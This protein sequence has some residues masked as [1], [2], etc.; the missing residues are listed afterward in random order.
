MT[1][2]AIEAYIDRHPD[3]FSPDERKI[4][5][6]FTDELV[7]TVRDIY[8]GTDVG[9]PKPPF[10]GD[11]TADYWG[12]VVTWLKRTVPACSGLSDQEIDLAITLAIGMDLDA[13]RAAGPRH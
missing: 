7:W 4:G 6:E 11:D 9:D 12:R 10:G 8:Y 3:E 2:A 5:L 1:G 13:P